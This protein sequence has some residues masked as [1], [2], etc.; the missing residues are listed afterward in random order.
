M[1]FTAYAYSAYFLVDHILYEINLDAFKHFIGIT[2]DI[3][4]KELTVFLAALYFCYQS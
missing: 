1:Q 2:F 4:H 3:D